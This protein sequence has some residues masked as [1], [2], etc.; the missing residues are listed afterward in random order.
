MLE[1]ANIAVADIEIMKR[2]DTNMVS[3]VY[4]HQENKNAV[5]LKTMKN[6]QADPP[7]E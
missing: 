7:P 3:K 2:A 4:R 6:L 1:T 5:V